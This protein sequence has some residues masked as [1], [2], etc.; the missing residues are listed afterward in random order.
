MCIKKFITHCSKLYNDHIHYSNSLYLLL[1]RLYIF[2]VF[3]KS[4]WLKLE[5]A[6]R[7]NW[8]ITEYLFQCEYNIPFVHY[9][10][11]AVLGTF[12][13]LFFPL[14]LLL[15]LVSRA[16]ALVIL[17]MIIVMSSTYIHL[18]KQVVWS[19]LA[20]N[21]LVFGSGKISVDYYIKQKSLIKY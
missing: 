20:A 5:N 17:L 3:L 19:I 4:G 7:G 21:I 2:T 16:S 8:Y 6:I 18:D 12:S 11:I 14:L 13:E 1:C 15:G 9:K 10:I